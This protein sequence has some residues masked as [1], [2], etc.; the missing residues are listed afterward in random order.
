MCN[1]HPSGKCPCGCSYGVECDRQGSGALLPLQK[2]FSGTYWSC[3]DLKWRSR[4]L[5]LGDRQVWG[6]PCAL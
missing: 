1:P 4:L 3:S 5:C 6:I 2:E